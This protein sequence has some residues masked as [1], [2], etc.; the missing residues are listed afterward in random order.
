[1]IGTTSIYDDTYIRPHIYTTYESVL[2]ALVRRS[3]RRCHLL[4]RQSGSDSGPLSSELCAHIRQS[5]SDSGAGTAHPALVRRSRRR[6]HLLEREGEEL[7]IDNLLVRIHLIIEMI[8]WTGLA[9]W[10]F[11]FPFPGSRGL[12]NDTKSQVEGSG[13]SER[14]S[15][16]DERDKPSRLQQDREGM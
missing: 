3:R 9:P 1:M 12:F 6:R 15:V 4:E 2:D 7:F 14:D 8:R 11:G 13:L 5:G 10:E 16:A